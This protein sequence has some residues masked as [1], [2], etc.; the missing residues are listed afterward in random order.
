MPITDGSNKSIGVTTLNDVSTGG[1]AGALDLNHATMGKGLR[2]NI[3]GQGNVV[4]ED[5][6]IRDRV[7]TDYLDRHA[8]PENI[9]NYIKELFNNNMKE[10]INK[11]YTTKKPPT[12]K[13]NM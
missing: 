5:R 4:I 2:L 8:H 9:N 7:I 10:I 3:L 1:Y 6:P 12:G 13:Q 11:T